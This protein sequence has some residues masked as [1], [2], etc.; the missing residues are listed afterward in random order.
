M[1]NRVILCII[2]SHHTK[3]ILFQIYFILI[4]YFIF[5]FKDTLL[6]SVPYYLKNIVLYVFKYNLFNCYNEHTYFVH[7]VAN[8]ELL[9]IRFKI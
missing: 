9:R 1:M 6:K 2:T 8:I 7:C 5:I 4:K 3:T